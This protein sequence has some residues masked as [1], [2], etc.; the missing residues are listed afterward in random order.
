[1]K[2]EKN[3]RRQERKEEEEEEE[4]QKISSATSS[5]RLLILIRVDLL[6]KLHNGSSK[7]TSDKIIKEIVS[8][9]SSNVL[10]INHNIHTAPTVKRKYY[11]KIV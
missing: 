11:V 8:V 7:N 5:N 2:K 10:K 1:M 4:E 3:Y 9:L 6:N